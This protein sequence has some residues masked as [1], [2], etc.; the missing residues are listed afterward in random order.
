VGGGRQRRLSHPCLPVSLALCSDAHARPAYRRLR[1]CGRPDVR[2][3]FSDALKRPHSRFDVQLP[4]FLFF[5]T[6]LKGNCHNHGLP[7]GILRIRIAAA[8]RFPRAKPPTRASGNRPC[9]PPAGVAGPARAPDP[10]CD[11]RCSKMISV[12]L[13]WPGLAS[14]AR[15]CLH[16]PLTL[17]PPPLQEPT[18][19]N[20]NC[21]QLQK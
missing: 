10:I 13:T 19:S 17:G 14:R 11:T 5:M 7:E 1:T 8:A 15:V 9:R 20:K 16:G 4:E 3:R 6:F 12:P 2:P 21:N 18:D